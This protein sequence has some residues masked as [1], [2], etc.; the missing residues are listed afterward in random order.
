MKNKYI[1]SGFILAIL[2]L[3]I[4][5]FFKTFFLMQVSIGFFIVD[6]IAVIWKVLMNKNNKFLNV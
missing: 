6:F 1:I 4:G 3:L 2:I 5:S